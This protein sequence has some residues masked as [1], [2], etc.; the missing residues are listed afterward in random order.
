MAVRPYLATGAAIVSAGALIAALPAIVP[1][2]TP[3]DVKIAAGVPKNPYVNDVKLQASLQELVD[4]FFDS[5][6]DGITRELLLEIV[7]SYQ[8]SIDAINGLFDGGFEEIVQQWLVNNN[9]VQAQRDLINDFFDGVP[10]D[11][12]DP[13]SETFPAGFTEL[14]RQWLHWNNF[15]PATAQGIDAFF[16]GGA[17]EFAHLFLSANVVDGSPEAEWL[18]TFFDSGFDGLARM[19]LLAA[20]PDAAGD[21]VINTF[22]DR[23]FDGLAHEFIRAAAPDATGK[24]LVDTFFTDGFDG[25]AEVF[26]LA[27]VNGNP[28]GTDVVNSFFSGYPFAIPDDPTTPDVDESEP[29]GKAGFV[30]LIHYVVDSLIGGVVPA[31]IAPLSVETTAELPEANS[32]IDPNARTVDLKIEDKVEA[33]V[34]LDKDDAVTATA[35]TGSAPVAQPAVAPAPA[36]APETAPPAEPVVDDGVVEVPEEEGEEGAVE[37]DNPGNKFEPP[38]LVFGNNGKRE[39]PWRKA[40][41]DTISTVTGGGATTPDA[42]PE[43]TGDPE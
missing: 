23:G 26:A 4:T 29:A 2:P 38:I 7:G 39:N 17:A 5:G 27:A 11:P 28:V 33:A 14:V 41:H 12:N 6:F 40:W 16:G 35:V 18:D 8:P 36:P 13:D 32:T 9:S 24:A 37:V 21:A 25:L 20:T 31:P 43:N 1:S 10:I 15:D 19:Y 22:F 42:E 30:G 34:E 3:P